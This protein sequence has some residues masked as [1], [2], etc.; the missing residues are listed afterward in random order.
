MVHWRHFIDEISNFSYFPIRKF[1][2]VIFFKRKVSLWKIFHIKIAPVDKLQENSR[3]WYFSIK[4]SHRWYFSTTKVSV[5]ALKNYTSHQVYSSIG[6]PHLTYFLKESYRGFFIAKLSHILSRDSKI[7]LMIPFHK[8]CLTVIIFHK[9]SLTSDS[10]MCI[11]SVMLVYIKI[12][13]GDTFL[14]KKSE[15]WSFCIE[16]V[17]W[18][19][20][21]IGKVYLVDVY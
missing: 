2:M 6:K 16:Y 9:K 1:S 12:L 21:S 7:F 15:L 19:Y 18:K 13:T 20:F 4:N 14:L 8:K 3:W 10:F 11:T 5:V 17:D